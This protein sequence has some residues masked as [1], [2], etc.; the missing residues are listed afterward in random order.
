MCITCLSGSCGIPIHQGPLL[1]EPSTMK[2]LHTNP[3]SEMGERPSNLG[4]GLVSKTSPV[5]TVRISPA[6]T[7]GN[8]GN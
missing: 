5:G 6:C 4:V 3:E 8:F 2:C 7:K 1:S